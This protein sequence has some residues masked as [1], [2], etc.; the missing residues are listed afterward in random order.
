M[1]PHLRTGKPPSAQPHAATGGRTAQRRLLWSFLH[2]PC[3]RPLLSPLRLGGSMQAPGGRLRKLPLPLNFL[4]PVR[5]FCFPPLRPMHE[6]VDFL[7]DQIKPRSLSL[8][9]SLP[10]RPHDTVHTCSL[11]APTERSWAWRVR[12][13][14]AVVLGGAFPLGRES[15]VL[16]ESGQHCPSPLLH[17]PRVSFGDELH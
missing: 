7:T 8:D 1:Q 12:L 10:P 13:S 9:Q 6:S 3:A 17:C 4:P 14:S 16:A 11:L 15:L 5:C 2:P